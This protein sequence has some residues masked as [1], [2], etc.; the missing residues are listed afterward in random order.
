M[1]TSALLSVSVKQLP[2]R[3][4]FKTRPRLA[5]AKPATNT[6]LPVAHRRTFAPARAAKDSKDW[7]DE[8]EAEFEARLAA[9]KTAKGQT[10]VGE[11]RKTKKQDTQTPQYV[12][13]SYDFTD[14]ELYYEGPPARGDLAVNILMGATLLWLPLTL[15]A[16]GRAIFVKY[17][18]TSKRLSVET[19]APWQK[20]KSDV[21]YQEVAKVVSIP[22]GVGLWGDMVVTLKNG[23]KVE[24]RALDRFKELQ[25]YI[26]ERRAEL[27]GERA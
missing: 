20:E 23:D 12:Q 5:G 22:R 16:V 2:T 4:C 13:K 27:T 14:E 9:L 19:S 17:K 11:S 25:E 26:L 15:A 10:P 1:V 3:Y 8:D 21:A 6:Q 24:L 18:F 7:T